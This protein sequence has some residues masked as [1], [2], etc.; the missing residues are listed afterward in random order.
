MDDIVGPRGG[1]GGRGGRRSHLPP[2]PAHTNDGPAWLV[3]PVYEV[4][5]TN[6]KKGGMVKTEEEE[7]SSHGGGSIKEEEEEER[8]LITEEY[9]E[10]IEK[11]FQLAR[12]K[13]VTRTLPDGTVEEAM[14]VLDVLPDLRLWSC[15][16]LVMRLPDDL[17]TATDEVVMRQP[18]IRLWEGGDLVEGEN[19]LATYYRRPKVEGGGGGYDA[20]FDDEE[21]EDSDLEADEGKLYQ[22]VTQCDIKVE[23]K[24]KRGGNDIILLADEGSGKAYYCPVG[25]SGEAIRLGKREDKSSEGTIQLKKRKVDVM[26]RVSNFVEESGLFGAVGEDQGGESQSQYESQ[27]QG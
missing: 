18:L 25:M 24:K 26:E 6:K 2:P 5:K 23:G 12:N 17:R 16:N 3:K 10:E 13:K 27:S 4:S 8:E 7:L 1:G 21:E 11:S 20:M 14:V 22:S 9:N 19:R 15:R